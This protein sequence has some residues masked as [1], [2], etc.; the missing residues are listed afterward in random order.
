M[1]ESGQKRLDQAIAALTEPSA[2]GEAEPAGGPVAA[3]VGALAASLASAAADRSRREWDEAPGARAQAEALRRRMLALAERDA[4]VYAEARAALAE[5]GGDG[6]STE[7]DA[8]LGA[9]VRVA[10]EV[11]L[12]IGTDAADVA[13]LA[14]TIARHA[15]ADV[16]ADAAI[17]AVLAAA[18]A[19]AA[20]QLVEINLVAGA[21][22]DL[23]TRARD[24][25]RA[26]QTAA[27]S[28]APG[29]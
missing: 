12:Q 2:D 4:S 28:V 5:R 7:R 3:A 17:A 6:D 8:R 13:Q 14:A 15:A 27:R 29:G 10:A 26:A 16:Q 24:C 22:T 20:A 18:A 21:D 11:P 1:I 9:A 23:V 19:E 25:A